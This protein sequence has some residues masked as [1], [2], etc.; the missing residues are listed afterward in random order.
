MSTN[1][2]Y[3]TL[4]EQRERICLSKSIHDK[5]SNTLTKNLDQN[6]KFKSSQDALN[7]LQKNATNQEILVKL[8]LL[9]IFQNRAREKFCGAKRK[10]K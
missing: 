4:W 10:A 8:C 7:N 1:K 5:R 6:A 3:L 2:L 9:K